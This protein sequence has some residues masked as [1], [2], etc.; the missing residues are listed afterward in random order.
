MCIIFPGANCSHQTDS[1]LLDSQFARD[2]QIS[3]ET[4]KLYF[5]K[6]TEL[7]E[8]ITGNLLNYFTR[9]ILFCL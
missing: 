1:P 4:N 2:S 5:R 6:L 3:V 8:M 9:I 7:S